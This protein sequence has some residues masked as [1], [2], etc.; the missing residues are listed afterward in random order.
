VHK[1]LKFHTKAQEHKCT[2]PWLY[3]T[4]QLTNKRWRRHPSLPNIST[5]SAQTEKYSRT[6]FL[7]KTLDCYWLQG[8]MDAGNIC[9]SQKSSDTRRLCTLEAAQGLIIATALLL[10]VLLF[11][12][13]TYTPVC[14][15]RVWRSTFVYKWLCDADTYICSTS[16]HEIG[17]S[18]YSTLATLEIRLQY[19]GEP[20]QFPRLSS[21]PSVIR[22]RRY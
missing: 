8:F 18:I 4:L 15:R 2:S 7:F 5:V 9:W 14:Y 22:D 16:I 13:G 10:R 6:L 1:I 20:D 11:Q 12:N 21:H 3:P 17:N 19:R